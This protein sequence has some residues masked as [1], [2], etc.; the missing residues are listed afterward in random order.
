MP[1][2]AGIGD[3]TRLFPEILVQAECKHECRHFSRLFPCCSQ[4]KV[5]SPLIKTGVCDTLILRVG[6]S[7]LRSDCQWGQPLW[8]PLMMSG[9]FSL[10]GGSA[11][12]SLHWLP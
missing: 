4:S 3:S 8:L 9:Q 5:R 6:I 7:G 11:G 1:T 10:P 2:S 12:L